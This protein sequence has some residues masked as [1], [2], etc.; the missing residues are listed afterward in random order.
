MLG[1][2]NIWLFF[3]LGYGIIWASMIWADRKREKPIEDPEFY[4]M[5]GGKKCM[6]IGWIWIIVLLVICLFTSVNFGILFWIGLPFYLFGIVL[7]LVA[8]NSFAQFTG[9]LNT[10][11]IYRYS[12]NPMYV[13]SF[14]FLLGLC[15]IGWSTT[16]WSIVLF[17][18]F[19][20]STPF[21]HWT[22]LLEEAFL[23]NKY[24]ETYREYMNK[25]PRYIGVPR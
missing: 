18:F 9:E 23:E 12:R 1:I 7:N 2:W 20:I 21:Y 4:Q 11:G 24:R 25:T 3:V 22:V 10:T 6:A 5:P 15:L 16:V 19:V 8:M 14:F 13:A 17:I